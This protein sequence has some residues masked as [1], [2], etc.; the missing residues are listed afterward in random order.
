MAPR[1]AIAGLLLSCGCSRASAIHEIRATESYTQK[2]WM[3][4]RK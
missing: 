4:L 3:G 1:L 2:L